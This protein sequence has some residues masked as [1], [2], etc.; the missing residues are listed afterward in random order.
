MFVILLLPLIS[1]QR[2]ILCIPNHYRSLDVLSGIVCRGKVILEDT[3]TALRVNI[4]SFDEFTEER[5]RNE[6]IQTYSCTEIVRL[7]RQVCWVDANTQHVLSFDLA[8]CVYVSVAL[9]KLSHL[10][11]ATDHCS[12][13]IQCIVVI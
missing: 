2:G 5:Y 13:Y 4:H 6:A 12:L 9:G 11:D 7:G 3:C 10:S 1:T 8:T